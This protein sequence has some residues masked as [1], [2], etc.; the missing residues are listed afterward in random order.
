MKKTL[1]SVAGLDPSA[2]AGILLDLQ[3]FGLHGFHGAA[4]LTSAT[5]QNTRAVKK[6]LA[7]PVSFLLDQYRALAADLPLAGIKV[8][9]LGS[10]RNVQAVSRILDLAGD[11]P[12]VIDPVFRSSSGFWLL[13]KKFIP[14]YLSAIKGKASLFTPNISEAELILGLKI[15]DGEGMKAAAGCIYELVRIPCLVKG[16]HLAQGR[17]VADVLYDGH[18]QVVITHQKIRK[19]V[20]GTGCFLSSTALA[21]LAQGW[22]LVRAC[23]RAVAQT[24]QAIALS[25]PAGRGRPVISVFSGWTGGRRSPHRPAA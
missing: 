9:M 17:E 3:V 24:M 12:R 5:A 2:G 11:I 13:G 21:Y 8:G 18:R 10:G 1:L 6:V 25:R 20:H 7:L 23:R 14:E 16:G 15:R 4:V 22:P 19:D